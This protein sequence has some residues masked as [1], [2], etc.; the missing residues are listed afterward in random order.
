MENVLDGHFFRRKYNETAKEIHGKGVAVLAKKMADNLPSWY[1][2][3]KCE[4]FA[5]R[6]P[7]ITKYLASSANPANKPK[8]EPFEQGRTCI[9]TNNCPFE[10]LHKLE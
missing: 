3:N 2:L 10:E 6:N 8:P 7:I 9:R 5:E 4:P 1:D